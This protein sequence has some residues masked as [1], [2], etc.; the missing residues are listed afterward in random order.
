MSKE[1]KLA[2]AIDIVRALQLPRAQQNERTALCLLAL[3]NLTPEKQW[4]Q[5]ENPLIGIT[6]IMEWSALHYDAQYA[7]NTRE[8]FRRQ[9]MHQFMQAAVAI[10]NPDKP[11]RPV[12]SPATVYQIEPSLLDLLKEYRTPE[13]DNR[14]GKYL[15]GRGSLIERYKRQREFQLIQV[16]VEDGQEIRLTPGKHNELAKM[17]LEQFAPRFTPGANVVYVGDTGKKWAYFDEAFQ[18]KLGIEASS[19]G[20]IPDVVLHMEE[21]EWLILI[22]IVT[23]HG[24]M[25]PKRHRELAEL[26]ASTQMGIIYVTA[27]PTRSAFSKYVADIA[28]E[29]EVWIADSPDHLVHFDGER[30]LGPYE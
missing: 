1:E 20:K 29:T 27:F 8:T 6:P 19:H 12:N 22:E 2:D 16:V 7:P 18:D 26:F 21:E 28:W 30:F 14:L 25:D 13:W 15:G 23:S 17:V 11:G 24:P 3:L 4:R 5:A 10:I 9:S